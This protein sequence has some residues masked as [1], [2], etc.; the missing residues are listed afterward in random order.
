MTCPATNPVIR[1]DEA[2]ADFRRGLTGPYA[3]DLLR[4]AGGWL[5]VQLAVGVGKTEWI[6]KIIA[7][8]LAAGGYD[9]VVVLVPLR[10]ILDELR[11]RLPD[12]LPVKVLHPRPR[13]RCGTL[14]APWLEFE[15]NG[16]GLLGREE[17][18]RVCPRRKGCSWLG[19]Y[20]R[21]GLRGAR[22]ILGTQQ[23]LVNNPQFIVRLCDDA[24]ALHP[25]V[26]LDE[27]DLF[28][29]SA[30]GVITQEQLRTFLAAMESVL[31]GTEEPSPEML[32]WR[33]LV[34][35]LT[36]APTP[37]LQWGDWRFP[38]PNRSWSVAVQRAGQQQAA[39]G[40]YR[41]LEFD[42]RALEWSDPGSRE[43]LPNGDLRTAKRFELNGHFI[44]FSGT[45]ARELVRYRLDPNHRRPPLASP[46]EGLRFEHPGTRWFNIASMRGAAK[47][48]HG[49]APSILDFFAEKVAG[50]SARGSGRY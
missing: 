20:G 41:H 37:D 6:L 24:G 40:E 23:H 46:F 12:D 9:L 25:L 35:L 44:V 36:E 27:S 31:T 29:R 2:L 22:V 39:G 8:A 32:T 17:L 15:R 13:K 30:E 11:R 43:R 49:G 7:H 45:T 38:R 42:L 33:Y 26:L 4:G 19:Q 16:C 10:S 18:C 14:D 1:G 28:L 21:K 50:T 3:L 5:L 34:E 47:Y 48:F